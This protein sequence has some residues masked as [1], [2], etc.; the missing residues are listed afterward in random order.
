MPISK[1]NTTRMVR[2]FMVGIIAGLRAIKKP[3]VD[4][5]VA[6]CYAGNALPVT[7]CLERALHFKG[8]C[9]LRA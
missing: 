9:A 3:P 5:Q 6:L 2:R 8:Y 1:A 4:Y 7:A